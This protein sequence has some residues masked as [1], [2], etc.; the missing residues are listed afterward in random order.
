MVQILRTTRSGRSLFA[1]A[2]VFVRGSDGFRMLGGNTADVPMIAVNAAVNGGEVNPGEDNSS[3]H[4]DVPMNGEDDRSGGDSE[5]GDDE[6]EWDFGT[7][8]D[9]R[10]SE[11][12]F[13]DYEKKALQQEDQGDENQVEKQ[14]LVADFGELDL[15]NKEDNERENKKNDQDEIDEQ[16][17]SDTKVSNSST[18][19]LIGTFFAKVFKFSNDNQNASRGDEIDE[20]IQNDTKAV[21][22]AVNDDD[23]DVTYHLASLQ[24]LARFDEE[25][26]SKN[27]RETPENA[28][29]PVGMDKLALRYW[30]SKYL[31]PEE[32]FL[33]S[34]SSKVLRGRFFSGIDG[35]RQEHLR[36][37]LAKL[38]RV[39]G[40]S[41][42]PHVDDVDVQHLSILKPPVLQPREYLRLTAAKKKKSTIYEW[43]DDLLQL[44]PSAKWSLKRLPSHVQ[45]K[46][47]H[48]LVGVQQAIK[49]LLLYGAGA[50]NLEE[51]LPQ[52]LAHMSVEHI[53]A[54]F[55]QP[56]LDKCKLEILELT[57]LNMYQLI[58]HWTCFATKVLT[59]SS[60]NGPDEQYE[61]WIA[62]PGLH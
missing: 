53:L 9:I 60:K 57:S 45:V 29:I 38:C 6:K 46:K 40:L 4:S 25:H 50:K 37:P 10:K 13:S 26:H 34:M 18:V 42:A 28:L 43:S 5:S 7:P 20:Q 39:S 22:T 15:E 48:S 23:H 24:T 36:S 14:K 55:A 16:I 58:S 21:N 3:D 31:S 56:R 41:L 12:G 8:R 61:C 54:I 19:G 11:D 33:V 35:R 30:L 32:L 51:S 52:Q 17:Q 59:C 1:A 27:L 2:L 62:R 44:V 49:K 47:S